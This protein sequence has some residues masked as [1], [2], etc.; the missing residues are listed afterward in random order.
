MMNIW[1]LFPLLGVLALSYFNPGCS[2]AD[3]VGQSVDGIPESSQDVGFIPYRPSIDSPEFQLCDS[4]LILSGRNQIQYEGGRNELEAEIRRNFVES[5]DYESYDGYIVVRFLVN[6]EGA[7]D[8]YRSQALA[9]DFSPQKAPAK[10][11]HHLS[12]IIKSL[13]KWEIQSGQGRYMDYSKYINLKMDN[14]KI[15]HVLL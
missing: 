9:L 2:S 11:V 8:R 12:D 6:C 4:T 14:G 1:A 3:S 7:R 13:T 5:E 15:K 10:L